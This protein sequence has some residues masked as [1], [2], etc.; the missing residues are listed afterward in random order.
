MNKGNKI[1]LA[2]LSF[3]VVCVVGY[4][5]FGENITVTGTAKAEGTFDIGVSCVTGFSSDFLDAG[6]KD[7]YVINIPDGGY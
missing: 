4:A 6:L 5:L 1:L 2:I 3:V 7:G